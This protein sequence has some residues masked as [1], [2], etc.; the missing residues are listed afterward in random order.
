MIHNKPSK[1]GVMGA[2][3]LLLFVATVLVSAVAAGVLIRATG[4]MEESAL[5][6]AQEAEKRLVSGVDIFTVYAYGNTTASK[7]YGL[8][9]YMRLRSGSPALQLENMGYSYISGDDRFSASLNESLVGE[10]CQF[11][12]LTSREQ[13]CFE[14]LNGNND[15]ILN[16]GELVAIKYGLGNGSTRLKTEENFQATFQI[17]QTGSVNSVEATIPSLILDTRIRLR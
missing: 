8:E 13:Y 5:G 9:Y 3:M 14:V 16:T 2:G 17:K 4:I 1:K 10:A 6:V 11:S 12:N 15:T 7:V